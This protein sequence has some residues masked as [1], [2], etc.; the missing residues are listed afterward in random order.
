[1]VLHKP[2]EKKYHVG[3]DGANIMNIH[4]ISKFLPEK[5]RFLSEHF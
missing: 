1:M 5:M 3:F 4:N 2:D